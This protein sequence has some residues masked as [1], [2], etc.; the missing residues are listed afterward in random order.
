M[1]QLVHGRRLGR[2]ITPFSG[3]RGEGSVFCGLLVTERVPENSGGETAADSGAPARPQQ[4]PAEPGET[5]GHGPTA[6]STGA[7]RLEPG[8]E[9]PPRRPQPTDP[10]TATNYA[11]WFNGVMYEARGFKKFAASP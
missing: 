4:L 11:L 6:Q 3:A 10:V 7:P 1:Y 8:Q 5:G 2:G 9:Y